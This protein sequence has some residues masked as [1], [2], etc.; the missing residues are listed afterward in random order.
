M[1]HDRNG[2]A[3]SRIATLG[4]ALTALWITAAPAGTS[5]AATAVASGP[6]L[7]VSQIIDKNAAARGGVEAWRKIRTM[8]WTGHVERADMPG[9]GMPFVLEQQRPNSTRFELAIQN[10]RGLRIYDGTNG[11]KLRP[12]G[13]GT[14]NIQPFTADE[15]NFAKD[16]QAIDGPLME[17]VA[18]DGVVSLIGIQEIEGRKAYA[19]SVVMP[20][21]A[22]HRIW[23]DAE[24][25]ME[26]RFE[27]DLRGA[28]GQP[29]VASVIY[30]NYKAFEGLQLPTI[31]ETGA[32]AGKP[33]NKLLIEKVA[34]NPPL[35]A[36]TFT[37]PSV[38]MPHHGVA[39]DTRNPPSPGAFRPRSQ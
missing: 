31:I 6:S 13:G 33:G 22:T 29:G 14:P 8:A 30:R 2:F 3:V 28:A 37:K 18:R 1:L 35:P 9:P 20:S 7:T 32:A 12:S 25:F 19:L 23:V 15:L 27:R 5:A 11:W 34:L 21:G 26:I 17:D 24:T 16:A 10:Q 39:V 36:N 38:S 4:I